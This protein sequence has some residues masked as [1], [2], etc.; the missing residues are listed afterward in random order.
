MTILTR[1]KKKLNLLDQKKVRDF[2][3][4]E[5]IDQV[6][7][8][9]ARVGGIHEN[10]NYPANFI[11]ENLTIQSNIIHSAFLSGVKKILFLGSSCIY[12]KNAN[13]PMKEEELLNGKLE[14]TNEPYAI[15]KIAGI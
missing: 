8:A 5:N 4:K 7:I 13:Q 9:A 6:Y 12:P 10:Y 1:S 14:F 11:Y 2:F 15:A 3:K